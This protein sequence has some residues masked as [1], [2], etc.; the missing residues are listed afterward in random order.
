[1]L[2]EGAMLGVFMTKRTIC[3]TTTALLGC[4]CIISALRAQAPQLVLGPKPSFG[5]FQPRVATEIF[6][7]DGQ[8]LGPAAN[9]FLLDTGAT[10]TLVFSPAT[11][12]VK[13]AG[14]I[15]EGTFED[16]GVSGPELFEVSAP[17]RVGYTGT[18]GEAEF[19]D[20]IRLL[21]SDGAVDP[22]GLLN[23]HGIV[24]M[25]AMEGRVTT[26]DN[27]TRGGALTLSTGVSFGDELPAPA[28]HRF[29]VPLT[30]LAFP[31]DGEGPLPSSTSLSTANVISKVGQRTRSDALV[32]DSGAQITIISESMAFDLGLDAN[33]DGELSDDAQTTVPVGGVGGTVQ[34]PVLVVDELRMPTDQGFEL[35]WQDASVI[36]LD[37]DPRINGVI[38]ADLMTDDGGLN[39]TFL[40][41]GLDSGLGDLLGDLLGGG[42]GDLF[43]DLLSDT[44][45]ED[46]LELFGDNSLLGQ[47]VGGIDGLFDT[48]PLESYFDQVHFDFRGFPQGGGA[49]VFDLNESISTEILNGDGVFDALDIDDLTDAIGSSDSVFDLD[50]NGSVETTDRDM[51]ITD[52]FQTTPGDTNLDRQVNFADFLVLADR[53]GQA[54][55]WSDGDFDGDGQVAFTDFLALSANFGTAQP[56][57]VP[58]PSAHLLAY[59]LVII[60]CRCAQ[61]SRAAN[62]TCSPSGSVWQA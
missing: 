4:L 5:L 59:G 39:L 54:G 36:A 42:F 44:G 37:I 40:G 57:S 14:Y 1:M 19:L 30:E 55:G 62:W 48:I 17:Y 10:S 22:T 34:A 21:S 9:S 33:G 45:L 53:F 16:I 13:E 26:V 29:T 15:V 23:L 50:G 28:T 18:S 2:H 35:T 52:V 38:G 46:L 61:Q 32:L 60:I 24:G 27:T 25:L 20:D 3:A 43:G 11:G 8:S 47:L 58:E 12:Q 7:S 41:N 51:L 6:A 49:L 31:L 56:V